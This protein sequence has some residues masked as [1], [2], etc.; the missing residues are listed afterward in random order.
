MGTVALALTLLGGCRPGNRGELLFECNVVPRPPRVGPA[1]VRIALLGRGRRPFLGAQ[2]SI[3]ADMSH[4][5]MKP[6][7]A[8]ASAQGG[9]YHSK[10]NFDMPGDWTLLIHAKLPDGETAE[11]QVPVTVR[12]K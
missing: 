3:E 10:L 12:E 5:G 8:E 7:F 11:D 1:D 9:E 6:V 4:P 2:V